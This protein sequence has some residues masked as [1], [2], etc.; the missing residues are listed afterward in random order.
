MTQINNV[1]YDGGSIEVNVDGVEFQGV[2]SVSWGYSSEKTKVKGVG[3]KFTGQTKGMFLVD[4]GALQLHHFEFINWQD[5]VGGPQ[6][7][8]ETEFEILVKYIDENEVPQ[9]ITLKRC[10]AVSVAGTATLNASDNLVVDVAFSAID[11][12]HN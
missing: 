1:F 7:F 2:E 8:L 6:A 5:R 11:I 10:R 3:R 9:N 12:D 4:D